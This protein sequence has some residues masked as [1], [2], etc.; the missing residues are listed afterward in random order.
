MA[1]QCHYSGKVRFATRLDAL[2]ALSEAEA[3][4]RWE[5]RYYYCKHCEGFHLTSTTSGKDT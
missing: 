3:K 4:G 5:K 2:F 1:E